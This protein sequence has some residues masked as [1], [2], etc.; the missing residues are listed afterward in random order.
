MSKGHRAAGAAKLSMTNPIDSGD[1]ARG[2]TQFDNRIDLSPFIAFQDENAWAPRKALIFHKIGIFYSLVPKNACTSILTALAVANGLTTPWFQSRNRIHNVQG[3]Y[4][5]LNNLDAFHDDTFKIVAFRNPLER[6]LSAFNNKLVGTDSEHM[7]HQRFFEQRL[8]KK[9]AECRFSEIV[10]LSD[11]VPHWIMDQHF[12]PQWSFLFYDRYDLLI[13]ADQPIFSLKLP[14][15]ELI[16][17]RHNRKSRAGTDEHIGDA[18]IAE[19][20]AF[21]A[22]TGTYPSKAEAERIFRNM[23]RPDG[24]FDR[25]YRLYRALKGGAAA[26]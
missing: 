16:L 19:I 8:N 26:T 2:L 4:S 1:A 14:D 21:L 11:Q 24:N 18:T 20:R 23:V 7:V 9:I 6:L 25:D 10:A 12:A 17:S 22:R 15:R 13:D 3:K 5:A